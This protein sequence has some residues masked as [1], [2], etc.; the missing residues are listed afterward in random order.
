VLIVLHEDHAKAVTDFQIQT[1]SI[2]KEA[3]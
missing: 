3:P 2:K 1:I